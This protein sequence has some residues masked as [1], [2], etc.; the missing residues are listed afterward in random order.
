MT[1]SLIHSTRT[2]QPTR[3]VVLVSIDWRRPGDGK[4]SLGIASIAAT[5]SAADIHYQLVESTINEP[6]FNLE[7][8]QVRIQQA[9]DNMG[10]NT[11][12]GFGVFVWND[13]AICQLISRLRLP[14]GTSIVL[15][16][17]QISY[18]PAGKL[19]AAYP[20]AQWFVRGAG[21]Q[22][23][24]RLA[25]DAPLDG[26]GVHV[27]GEP[28]QAQQASLPLTGL[29]SPFMHGVVQMAPEMRWET[30]RGCQFKCSFCQHRDAD[31]RQP[32]RAFDLERLRAEALMFA[33]H[34]VKRISI[35]DPIFH[36]NDS[37]AIAVLNLLKQ[38]GVSAKIALQCRFEMLTEP[39]LNAL[40]GLDVTLEFGL[41]TAIPSESKL[42]QRSNNMPK[43]EEKLALVKQ[44]GIDFEVS[45]IYGLP[46]Q[47]L[48]SFQRSVDWCQ[49]QGIP[50]VK[51]WPL[52]LLRGTPLYEQK[53][54]YAMRETEDRAIP[55]VIASDSF[56]EAEYR[57]MANIAEAL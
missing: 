46:T 53:N 40:Q 44:R 42:I 47:T 36:S 5:L 39:F 54:Q 29:A 25:Q 43:V 38:A 35:L 3:N 41:Q 57:T 49:H 18:M 34:R 33:T 16:G 26:C 13:E 28:D 32:T 19:E 22:A 9:L 2:T 45:L 24:L 56:T 27:V 55:I 15:G 10:P 14:T 7:R 6:S 17:P 4:T 37:H 52:M 21:E 11:L 48:E 20:Q 31:G 1:S 23:M 8:E 12:L 50:R 51:A 30:Q